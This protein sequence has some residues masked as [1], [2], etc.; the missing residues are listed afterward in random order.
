MD[1]KHTVSTPA[2]DAFPTRRMSPEDLHVYAVDAR[3]VA[4]YNWL[5]I[6]VAHRRAQAHA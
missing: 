1:E 2:A 4:Q 3:R 5:L 6:A